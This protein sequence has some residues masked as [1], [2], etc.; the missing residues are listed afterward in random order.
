M[1]IIWTRAS[2]TSVK[3]GTNEATS[4]HTRSVAFEV[5]P[6]RD[7]FT[8]V[9]WLLLRYNNF[10]SRPATSP[11]HTHL[12]YAFIML[13]YSSGIIP[14]K[15]LKSKSLNHLK[16]IINIS[17]N[18]ESCWIWGRAVRESCL[19]YP[20]VCFFPRTPIIQ[21]LSRTVVCSLWET[22]TIFIY[23][24]IDIHTQLWR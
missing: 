15:K 19:K 12:N 23:I 2:R 9:D 16:N 17:A 1:W 14:S 21:W 11:I 6:S 24:D 5:L 4:Q 8:G 18:E 22:A 13:N 7:C 10:P 20:K 3:W